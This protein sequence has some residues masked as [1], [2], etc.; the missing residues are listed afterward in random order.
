LSLPKDIMWIS[1]STFLWTEW[2]DSMVEED[3][4]WRGKHNSLMEIMCVNHGTSFCSLITV[5]KKLVQVANLYSYTQKLVCYFWFSNM[6][7]VQFSLITEHSRSSISLMCKISIIFFS[8][9]F[10]MCKNIHT[11]SQICN[12]ELICCTD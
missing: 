11:V 3:I 9:F 10:L 4:H 7:Q 6:L 12:P 1:V 8:I 2:L 5:Q